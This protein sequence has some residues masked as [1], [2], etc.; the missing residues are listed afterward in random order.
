MGEVQWASVTFSGVAW[1]GEACL[2]EVVKKKGWGFEVG[3]E[4]PHIRITQPCPRKPM[5]T[6]RFLH[7][8]GWR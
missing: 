6:A 3:S 7:P 8:A 1:E 5:G 2:L 4:A